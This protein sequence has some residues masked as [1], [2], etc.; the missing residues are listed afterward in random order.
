MGALFYLQF[1]TIVNRQ[2][3]R[4]Q[5]LKKPK[6]LIGGIV[7]GVYFYFY[8]FRFLFR[9]ARRS[10]ASM[11][12]AL[13]H[14][15]VIE[16]LGAATLLTIVLLAWIIPHGRAALTFSEAEV[17]FLFPAPVSRRTLIHFK[18]LKSQTGILFTTFLLTLFSSRVGGSAVWIRALGWW[19]ILLTL[20]LHFLGSSF[21]RSMLLEHGISNWKR[22]LLV[23]LLLTAFLAVVVIWSKQTLPNLNWAD[24]ADINVARE[25]F[26]KVTS[27][28]PAP[29]L[30]YP[31]RLIVRPYLAANAAQFAVA[32]LPALVVLLAHYVWVM[33]ANV[34]FEEASVELSQRIAERVSA[35][36]AGH[37]QPRPTKSKRAP[38]R[39]A[40]QG[41]P[42]VALLW[43]NL[44]AA[45]Q[46]F[47]FRIWVI[48]FLSLFPML[49]VVVGGNIGHSEIRS[50]LGIGACMVVFWSLLIGPQ[51]LRH[52]FRNDLAV[53][54]ILKSFPMR[55]WQIVLGELLGPTA[56]LTGIQWLL[57]TTAALLVTEAPHGNVILPG[58][59]VALA[60]GAAMIVP[61]LNLVSLIVPNA[62]VL[63]F[64][65]WFQS[66][67]EG[68]HGVEATGQRLI[69]MLGQILAFV[70]ALIPAAL[71]FAAIF[72][73]LSY[74]GQQFIGITLASAASALMLG[75]ESALAIFLLGRI[76]ENFDLSAE[77][78]S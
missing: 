74:F 7:G 41:P 6:Y 63:L 14:A 48:L 28:G 76:F 42:A 75:I 10:G 67:R 51:V 59:R 77:S 52:D 72:F 31:F 22:R 37:L 50:V 15:Q 66:G 45:G 20:N 1:W 3:L 55:G 8:F 21:V 61:M 27:A 60:I 43:K 69:F 56:I 71:A 33:R 78:V 39:L 65:G 19:I 40:S 16:A 46:M 62:S 73:P 26:R 24:L 2:K 18:L 25:Y 11:N 54:D 4:L 12:F 49:L 23:L 47:S 35:A 9:G 36:R 38:F 5:R 57:I 34:A 32:A 29:Y 53:A 58:L 64:P 68:P 44:I 13:D 17:N 30:L 70:A